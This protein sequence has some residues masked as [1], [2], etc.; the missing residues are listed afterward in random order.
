MLWL[1]VLLT[2]V[3]AAVLAPWMWRTF[4]E[5]R[6]EWQR[7]LARRKPLGSARRLLWRDPGPIGELDLTNGPGGANGA[8]VP[9]FRFLKEHLSGS[10]ACVSVLDALGR[11]WRV[12]WGNEVKTE[13]FGTRFAWAAGY[14]AEV[15]YFM[16]DG[17]IDQPCELGRSR[18]FIDADGR[19]EHARFELEESGVVKHFDEGGWAWHDNPFVGTHE[20]N[21]LKIVMM[22]LSNWDNKDVRDTARGSNTAIFEYPLAAGRREARYLIID[23]GAALGSWG[24]NILNRGRWD[25]DAF[26]RQ[27][28]QFITAVEGDL[29]R[30]GYQGQRTADAVDNIL[31]SDVAWLYD[32]LR[33]LRDDQIAQALRASGAEDEEV[34]AFTTALRVRLDQLGKVAESFHDRGTQSAGAG[35]VAG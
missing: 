18:A 20:L 4:W 17:R 34:R 26:A 22:L 3:A 32:R 23:W 25:P 14:F 1:I 5:V 31:M 11:S 33:G 13:T 12:K 24:S 29:V 16:R 15:T 10:H 21:G 27:N 2:I 7:R 28:D 35:L 8:P 6:S 19:F 30:W 9:P